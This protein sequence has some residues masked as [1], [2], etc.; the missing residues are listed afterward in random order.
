MTVAAHK[1]NGYLD[2]T[3]TVGMPREV[4]YQLFARVT[5]KLNRG[6]RKDL[7]FTDLVEALHENLTLWRTLALEVIDDNNDLPDQLRAQIFYLFEFTRAHTPKVMRKEA[8]VSAL[9]DINM[10]IM[11]GLRQPSMAEQS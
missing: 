3:K 2:A 11:R 9:V 10:S 6:Y 4:E 7:D 8:D 1:Q 5:G